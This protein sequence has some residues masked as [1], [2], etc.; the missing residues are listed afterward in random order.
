MLK[1]QPPPPPAMKNVRLSNT[2]WWTQPWQWIAVDPRSV[3][4]FRIC[5]GLVLICDLLQQVPDLEAFFSDFG[6][7]PRSA[8]RGELS[9]SLFHFSV[10]WL[11]GQVVFIKLLFVL[12]LVLATGL[13]IGWKTRWCVFGSWVLLL[14]CL[15][16]T[17]P[18]PRDKRQSR[19]PSSA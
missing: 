4:L 7:Y 18:S 15:L 8:A 14:S 9:A 2:A 19:M 10:Y 13:V 3:A 5:L 6:V 11:G 16:Y 1:N 17:S 12:Q